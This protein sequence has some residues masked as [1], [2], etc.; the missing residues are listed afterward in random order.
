MCAAT[1]NRARMRIET[2]AEPAETFLTTAGRD[3]LHEVRPM[4][5]PRFEHARAGRSEEQ[6]ALDS[7]ARPPTQFDGRS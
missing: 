6:L 4:R 7:N 2:P 3:S 1:G 5:T